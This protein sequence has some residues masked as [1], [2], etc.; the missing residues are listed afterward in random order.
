MQIDLNSAINTFSFWDV[1]ICAVRTRA[2]AYFSMKTSVHVSR[3]L[4]IE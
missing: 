2:K 3:K 1:N 4:Y